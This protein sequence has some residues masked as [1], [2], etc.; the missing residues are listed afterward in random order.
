MG[1]KSTG[2]AIELFNGHN[3]LTLWQQ[4]TKNILTREG[5]VKA[6]KLKHEK[7]EGETQEKWEEMREFANSTIQL[8]LENSTLRE[9]I[10][11]TDPEKLWTKLESRHKSKSLTNRSSLK[12]QLY[13][14]HMSE[15]ANFNNHLDEFNQL[16]MELDA[17]GAK[18][19]KE[20]K[21]ILLLFSL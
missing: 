6:L 5:L 1:G 11:E 4:R 14:L 18:I 12:K 2:F 8:C 15:G 13:A 10:N 16:L 7:P 9:L 19:E 3:N 17:I 21:A 20:D